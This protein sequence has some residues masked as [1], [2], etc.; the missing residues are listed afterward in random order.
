MSSIAAEP[1]GLDD[2]SG[3]VGGATLLS[4]KKSYDKR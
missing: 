3:V 1:L 4:R 2:L